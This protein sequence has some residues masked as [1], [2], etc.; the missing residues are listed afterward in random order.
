MSD[1]DDLQNE[2]NLQFKKLIEEYLEKRIEQHKNSLE[3]KQIVKRI[4]FLKKKFRNNE[5]E[6]FDLE[7]GKVKLKKYISKFSSVL[8]KDFNKLSNK[9][10]K[11][12]FK[13]GLLKLK[14]SLNSSKYQK[15]L[16]QNKKTPLDDFV[17]ERKN[18]SEYYLN[19][20]SSDK[21]QQELKDY[22]K[23]LDDKWKKWDTELFSNE[24]ELNQF[25]DYEEEL[26][27][28]LL[29]EI[30]PDPYYFSDDDPADM[31]DSP[32]YQ[33]KGFIEDEDLFYEDEDDRV[34]FEK[35][36]LR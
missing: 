22:Q 7:K 19:M 23:I 25:E 24:D 26:I 2:E 32:E 1:V 5:T 4:Y 34:D 35:K 13:T 18:T 11:E 27:E 21:V 28:E 15:E 30:K 29:E 14:F 10:K 33:E 6:E 3:L 12:I 20:L 31:Q 8:S 9:E 16:E 36:I 17:N